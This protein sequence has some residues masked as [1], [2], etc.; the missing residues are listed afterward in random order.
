MKPFKQNQ[1]RPNYFKQNISQNGVNFLQKKNAQQLRND[2]ARVFRDISKRNID[3]EKDGDYFLDIGFISIAIDVAY[4]GY[5]IYYANYLG[6][7]YLKTSGQYNSSPEFID[8]LMSSNQKKF[9]AYNIMYNYLFQIRESKD[10]RILNTL[11]SAMDHYRNI[12]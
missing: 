6:N 5:N 1:N 12:L 4:E 11:M 3:I 2:M 8:S 10:L 7:L 9:E